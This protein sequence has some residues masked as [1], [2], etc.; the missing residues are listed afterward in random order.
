[1]LHD[2]NPAMYDYVACYYPEGHI[3]QD[4]TFVFNHEDIKE[5]IFKGCKNEEEDRF[6][7][8]LNSN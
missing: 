4:Y 3:N 5:V 6:S 8:L 2:E 1:M 7:Q